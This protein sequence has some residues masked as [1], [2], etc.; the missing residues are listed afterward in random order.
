[1]AKHHIALAMERQSQI[2]MAARL[3]VAAR[4]TMDVG[5]E[6]TT[7]QQQN[8]LATRSECVAR[9]AFQRQTEGVKSTRS[10]RFVSQ[11]DQPDMGQWA[12]VNTTR[13]TQ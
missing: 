13:Q 6:P 12:I 5:G 11:I 8:N 1:M 2:A 4:R 10:R 3:D 7:I 9:G